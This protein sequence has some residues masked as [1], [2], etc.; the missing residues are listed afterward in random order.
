VVTIV[1]QL[2]VAA[3][4]VAVM[5]AAMETWLIIKESCTFQVLKRSSLFGNKF[6]CLT[7]I[8]TDLNFKTCPGMI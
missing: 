4:L 5:T 6:L 3:V 7:F 1:Q 2:S 8:K